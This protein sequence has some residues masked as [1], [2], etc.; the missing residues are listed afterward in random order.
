MRKWFSERFNP[1]PKIWLQKQEYNGFAASF[2][3]GETQ[4]IRHGET[5]F[6]AVIS[7]IVGWTRLAFFGLPKELQ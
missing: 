7:A 3:M 1:G 4:V 5:A 2:S 6:K